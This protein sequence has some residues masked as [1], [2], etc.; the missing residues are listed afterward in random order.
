[1]EVSGQ[2]HTP[3]ALLPGKDSPGTHCIGDWVGLRTDLDV[4]K[5]TGKVVPVRN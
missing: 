4:V 3:T 1:M 2:L 5:G